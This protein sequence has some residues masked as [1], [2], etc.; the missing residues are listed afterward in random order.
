VVG[1]ILKEGQKSIGFFSSEPASGDISLC[2][3]MNSF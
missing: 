1:M 2:R 3:Y